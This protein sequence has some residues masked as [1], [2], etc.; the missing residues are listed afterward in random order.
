MQLN[1]RKRAT[2]VVAGFVVGLVMSAGLL[3][4]GMAMA[5]IP[6][7]VPNGSAP[8]TV[9][10]TGKL[11]G[12][13]DSKVRNAGPNATFRV[14]VHLR[15]QAD[16]TTWPANDRTG[17][18]NVLRNVAARSQPQVINAAQA[19]PNVSISSSH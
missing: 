19:A 11:Y 17:A 15:D 3:G 18:L 2:R 6:A 10:Q 12:Q 4:A 7:Q 8:V 16:L 13:L 5:G 14:I 9:T 1:D